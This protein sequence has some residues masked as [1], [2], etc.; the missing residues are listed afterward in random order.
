MKEVKTLEK[1]GNKMSQIFLNERFLALF[2]LIVLGG[3]FGCAT[4]PNAEKL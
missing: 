4:L 1:R 3:L 2:C